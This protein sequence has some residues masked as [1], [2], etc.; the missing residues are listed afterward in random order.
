M[1]QWLSDLPL[2]SV[3]DIQGLVV[4]ADV[5]SCSQT[6]VELA[7]ERCYCVSRAA[8]VLPFLLEV[9]RGVAR[10]VQAR[11]GEVP[12]RGAA[13]RS[14]AE[15]APHLLRPRA[16]APQHTAG[17][18][19]ASQSRGSWLTWLW[20]R[21]RRAAR[22]GGRIVARVRVSCTHRLANITAAARAPPAMSEENEEE[23]CVLRRLCGK[24]RGAVSRARR[25]SRRVWPARSAD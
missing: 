8:T 19:L 13:E 9:R 16:A 21:A 4:E 20:G 17:P 1:T 3:I 25:V 6:N 7:L 2:E 22:E 18:L 15:R 24:A 23:V 5:K 12:A 14:E 10:E 11:G